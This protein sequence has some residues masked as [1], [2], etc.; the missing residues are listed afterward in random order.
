[1]PS[2]L[3]RPAGPP[4]AAGPWRRPWLTVVVC[5]VTAAMAIAQWSQPE[6][7]VLLGRTPAALHGEWWRMV[8][9]LVVQDGGVIGT[10]SNVLFLAVIGAIAEQVI[11]RRAWLVQYVGVGVAVELLAQWWQPVGAGNSIAVC[12]LT[13]AIALAAWRE[14]PALPRWAAQA[15]LLWCG[16][17][18]ATAWPPLIALGFVGA[19]VARMR[20]EHGRSVGP[21]VLGSV[22]ATGVALTALANIH[23]AALVLGLLLARMLG[24]RGAPGRER[25]TR[26]RPS[27]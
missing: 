25:T 8:T 4:R 12:G 9:A 3:E 5:A 16:A 13:G 19:G 11:S 14:D 10:G 1:M 6:L 2:T 21:F 27:P 23:G 15:V 18:L 24:L 22:T 7:L 17:L 26:A 20:R